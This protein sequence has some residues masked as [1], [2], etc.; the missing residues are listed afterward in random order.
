MA[1][2]SIFVSALGVQDPGPRC[3]RERGLCCICC[4]PGPRVF[5]HLHWLP[6]G[7]SHHVRHQPYFSAVGLRAPSPLQAVA[8]TVTQ[9]RMFWTHCRLHGPL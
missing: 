6:F 9:V 8:V 7:A 3:E 1:T 5:T 4:G 2:G